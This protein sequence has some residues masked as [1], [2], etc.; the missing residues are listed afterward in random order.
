MITAVSIV[1]MPQ[2]MA[3]QWK[4]SF[5]HVPD[6]VFYGIMGLTVVANLYM[7]YLSAKGLTPKIL[8]INVV[9]LAFCAVYAVVRYNSGKVNLGSVKSCLLYTSR[10]V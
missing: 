6:G 4:K 9:F 8:M 2:M 3:E 7:V 5:L 10:C 1:R